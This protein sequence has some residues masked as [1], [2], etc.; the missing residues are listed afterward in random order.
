M[1]QIDYNTYLEL[2]QLIDSL[3]QSPDLLIFLRASVPTLLKQIQMRGR[4]YEAGIRTEYLAKL[5]ERYEKWF[6]SYPGNKVV[7]DID[8]N[9][10][11]QDPDAFYRVLNSIQ[12][13]LPK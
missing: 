1:K 7:I 4:T 12:M 10:F 6:D 3:V 2:F 11:S 5:N 8:Q 9:D 13:A